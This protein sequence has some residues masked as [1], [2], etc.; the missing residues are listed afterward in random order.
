MDDLQS[1]FWLILW[2]I[3]AHLNPGKNTQAEARAMLDSLEQ[4]NLKAIASAKTTMLTESFVRNGQDMRHQLLLFKNEWVIEPV[5]SLVI[6]LG[7][8]FFMEAIASDSSTCEPSVIFPQI[9]DMILVALS[10]RPDE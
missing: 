6:R 1:F 3:A 8:F 2:S 7:S 5:I 9:V 10:Q 4:S